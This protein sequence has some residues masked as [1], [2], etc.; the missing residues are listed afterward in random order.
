MFLCFPWKSCLVRL[1]CHPKWIVLYFCLFLNL[2]I[3]E[4]ESYIFLLTWFFSFII[5]EIFIC[6]LCYS[7]SWISLFST[8]VCC[9]EEFL[10][11][12]ETMQYSRKLVTS[13]VFDS[14]FLKGIIIMFSL[15]KS[16]SGETSKKLMLKF[17]TYIHT[18]IYLSMCV[19]MYVYIK[20][21]FYNKIII[22]K[23]IIPVADGIDCESC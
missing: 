7:W 21:E 6:V 11:D 19:C 13:Q 8:C 16:I 4:I 23:T 22:Y 9:Y 18:C 14:V 17:Y 3:L 5:S 12:M 1:S 2:L 10:N 20:W 15:E